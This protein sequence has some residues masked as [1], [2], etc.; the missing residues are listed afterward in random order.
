M[1][2]MLAQSNPQLFALIGSKANISQ[3]LE[4]I[5]KYQ[6]LEQTSPED[7]MNEN[8]KHWEE[9]LQKYCVRVEKDQEN[10]VGDTYFAERK[11]MMNANNPAHILRN[12]IAQNAIDAAEKG[13]FT[14]VRRVLKMLENPYEEDKSFYNVSEASLQE[15]PVEG[16][17]SAVC[18]PTT[19]S[20]VPY[21]S[22]PP[23]WATELCVT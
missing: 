7:L 12:Y 15:E 10:A 4:R 2:L 20:K 6:K 5:E 14:E 11:E 21:N 16:A 22:K 23:L 9:W 8:K 17:A 3:E 1:M 13:D 18:R 19:V